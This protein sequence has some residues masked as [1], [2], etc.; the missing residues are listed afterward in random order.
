MSS[1]NIILYNL[2]EDEVLYEKEVNQRVQIASLT[3]IMTALVTLD[4]VDD[5]D[6]QVII[7]Y[8]DLKG[9]KEQNLVTAGF[10]VGSAV[11]YRDLLYGLLLPSGA[12]A[13]SCLSRNVSSDFIGLMNERAKKLNLKD[14]HFSNTIGLD[15][16]NNYSS[17]SDLLVL[18]KEALKNKSFREIISSKNYTTSDGKLK[19]S[20]SILSNS[21]KYNIDIPYIIGGKTGTTDGAGLCLVSL[22]KDDDI[23]LILVTTGAIYDKVR[24]H[25]IDDAKTIY[26]YYINNYSNEKIVDRK[27]SFKTLKTV[28][29]N[30]DEIKIYP[31][32]DVMK[33]L[34]SDYDKNDVKLI[35]KGLDRIKYNTKGKIGTL[36]VYY[37]DKLLDTQNVYMN[38]KLKFSI[39]KF[40]SKNIVYIVIGI[41]GIVSI[42]V[43]K[44][45]V[46]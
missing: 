17:V 16:S 7:T 32:K 10:T 42:I 33:Y 23:D 13:A 29:A 24:P 2:S 20:S 34:P 27:K 8:D 30:K 1:K 5:L 35:Y 28:Y 45:R 3:K 15:D 37:Q 44:K 39:G 4:N 38:E 26:D 19:F 31:K 21:K 36:K 14:T 25:H 6:K 18:F 46:F 41:L 40:I 11:T 12:D 43:I 9:L 22:A